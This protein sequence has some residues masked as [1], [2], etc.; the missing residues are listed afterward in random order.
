MPEHCEVVGV[1]RE[2]TGAFGQKYAVKFHM[3]LPVEWNGR[4]LF[5][6]GGGTNGMVGDASGGAP[7]QPSALAKGFAVVSTDTGHDNAVNSDPQR[8]GQVA[9]G[10]DYQARLEYSETALDSVATTAKRIVRLYYGSA[11]KRSYFAGCSNGGREGMEFAQRF[12]DQ[13]DGIV[14]GAPAF[15]VPKAAVAE[16]YDTQVF[17]A[18]ATS[19]GL[20][21]PQ[22]AARYGADLLE[23]RPEA[24]CGCRCRGV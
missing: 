10:H 2:R 3:R 22:W 17:S 23:F 5:Q 15:A 7:G 19:M 14:A 18:L 8:Q 11:P 9:F 16:A 13:F 21:R 24:G 20:T 6:G 1:M 4:F 12:P